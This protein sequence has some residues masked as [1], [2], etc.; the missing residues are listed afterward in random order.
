MSNRQRVH[1]YWWNH[2][3]RQ[4]QKM[5]IDAVLSHRWVAVLGARQRGKTTS[6]GYAAG[7][8]AQ[9]AE[10]T[11]QDGRRI[12]LP[13]DDVQLASQTLKHAKDFVS[14]S[15][16]ILSTFNVGLSANTA[17]QNVFDMRLGST[18]RIMLSTGRKVQAHAGN[19]E[20]IQGL[21]GHVFAD[22]IASNKHDSEA[23]FQQGVSVASGAP[24]RRFVMVGNSSYKGDWWWNF[25]HGSGPIPGD[26]RQTWEQRRSKFLMLKLDIWSEFPDRILPPDLREIREILGPKAWARWY[27]CAFADSHGRAIPDELIIRTGMVGTVTPPNAPIVIS[28]DPGLNRNPTGVV[29]ARVGSWGLDVLRAEYWYGPTANDSPT[30][31]GWVRAQMAQIDGYVNQYSP[32]HIVVDYSNLAARLGDALE[33]VYG[34]MMVAKTPTTRDRTQRRWGALLSML[35][36]GRL[37]IPEECQDLRDDLGRF[38][39]DESGSASRKILEA[40]TLILPESPA[41]NGSHVLHCDIGAALLQCSD[42]VWSDVG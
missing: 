5:L 17:D 37:S 25:W 29:V 23:I 39:I 6:V 26:E 2:K 1:D 16:R 4:N 8:L 19:P 12:H 31:E 9:G 28:I 18:E 40:G 34:D 38:E 35:T 33:E 27:E 13:P 10:W 42:Y 24:H 30:A 21:S 15:S 20:T 3:L 32:D 11:A 22:E 14:R 36:D 7:A 41:P